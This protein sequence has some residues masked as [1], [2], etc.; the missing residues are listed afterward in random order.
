[1]SNSQ[2]PEA[3]SDH[4]FTISATRL[5]YGWIVVVC[6]FTIL[7][8]AYGIQF[9]FGVFMPFISA[10]TGW[11]RASLSLP[12]S[13]YIFVYSALGV[14][15]G[16]LTDRFG[17]RLVLTVGGC[18]LGVGVM[19]VSR[20][21][22]LWQLYLALG[23]IAAAGMSAVYVPC[24]ATVVRWFMRKRGL[25][26]SITSSG[27]SFGMFIF[28]PLTTGLIAMLGWRGAY[29]ILGLLGIITVV[30]CAAF[31]VRDPEKIGLL[32]DGEPSADRQ[33][34]QMA[35]SLL[36][37]DDNWTLHDAKRTTAFW[38]LNIIFTLTWLVVFMPMVHI[39]PFAV[40]LGISPFRAAM[41]ISVIGFAGF[42][43]RLS[44]GTISDRLG[45][46]A[47]LGACLMMQ[48][49]AFL[50]FI[51]STGLGLLYPAAALFG[52]SYGGI[53]ALFPALIGDFFGRIAVGA[54]V[55]FI[56]ALAGSPAAF[57]PLIAG[58]IYDG[59]HSYSAAFE[60]SAGLNLI[61]FLLVFRLK[62]P[63]RS[64]RSCG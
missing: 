7:C 32:P 45:R 19:L 44:I 40:D 38:L 53:T 1:M 10:D 49:L 58:Y 43:G 62:K 64:S 50:G 11:D 25:A 42:G 36:L 24:N 14:V 52:F 26:L 39:V 30:S 31:I 21:H 27:A 13:L 17:P 18:L 59:T 3:D 51:F 16:R 60:L 57:G 6:A 33:P 23:L 29:F 55:G 28:P 41:T 15:S 63:L 22:V 54:I 48:A 56:F 9:S 47:T 8:V 35:S 61:A 12:Y 4:A 20:A 5:F 2:A 46:V 34:T 37:P